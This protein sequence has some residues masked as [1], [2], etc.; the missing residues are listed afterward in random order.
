MKV[1]VSSQGNNLDALVD[2]R[3]GRA[4]WFVIADSVSGAWEAVDNGDNL[5][6]SGGAG[7]EA[8]SSVAA[9][10]VKALVTGNVGPNAHRVLSTAGVEVFQAGNGVTVREALERLRHGELPAVGTPTV[11]G[12]WA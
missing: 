2:P 5:N 11:A 1:A 12:H 3:F 10:G 8:G 9:R 6:A 4:R 7:V